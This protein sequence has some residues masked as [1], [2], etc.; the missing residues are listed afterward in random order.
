MKKLIPSI[1]IAGLFI[2]G[3]LKLSAQVKTYTFKDGTKIDAEIIS[4]EPSDMKRAEGYLGYT[5]IDGG[6]YFFGLNYFEPEKYFAQFQFGLTG[7]AIDGAY[8]LKSKRA[9][10]KVT[11]SLK[12]EGGGNFTTRWVIDIPCT[13]LF[14]YGIHG[15]I[16]SIDFKNISIMPPISTKVLFLGL[17]R[18]KS[19]YAKIEVGSNR[20]VKQGSTTKRFNA[21][22]MLH[23]GTKYTTTDAS[24]LGNS[25]YANKPATDFVSSLGFRLYAE[26]RAS[27]W[28]STGTFGVHYVYGVRFGGVQNT[29]IKVALILGLGLSYGFK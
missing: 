25:V 19:R 6:M 8:Y 15:G 5:P 4:T 20:T 2:S 27:S 3:A 16:A 13:K 7:F 12:S 21:D 24:I 1:L 22:V 11:Q 10:T 23:M 26:G 14:S 17:T 29:S 28:G 9:D 18:V